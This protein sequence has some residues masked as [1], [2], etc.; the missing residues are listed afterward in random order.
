[1]AKAFQLKFTKAVSNVVPSG[2]EIQVIS[3]S[4][5]PQENEIKKALEDAGFKVG[6]NSISG[7]YT[8]EG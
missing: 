2:L 6:G 3:T 8:V 4:S 5:R 1:M 7:T